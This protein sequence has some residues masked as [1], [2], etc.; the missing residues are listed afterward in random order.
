MCSN[1]SGL[2]RMQ[3]SSLTRLADCVH[4]TCLTNKYYTQDASDLF[5]P[6][7][8]NL[9]FD[10]RRAGLLPGGFLNMDVA[11]PGSGRRRKKREAEV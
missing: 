11:N 3:S 5:L 4:V 10:L 8:E 1:C 6:T 2:L 9:D 7:T